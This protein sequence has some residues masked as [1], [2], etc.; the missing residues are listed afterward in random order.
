MSGKGDSSA[1]VRVSTYGDGIDSKMEEED[2]RYVI[3]ELKKS[4]ESLQNYNRYKVDVYKSLLSKDARAD[5]V[6][7]RGGKS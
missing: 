5:S 6:V 4:Q 1:M 2:T 3:D 7:F